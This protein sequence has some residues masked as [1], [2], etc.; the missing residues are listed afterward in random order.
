MTLEEFWR[1]TPR[2]TNLF[3]M[4]YLRR[5]AWAA[6]HS[7]YGMQAKD[8]RIEDLMFGR[9]ERPAMT[10]DQMLQNLRRHRVAQEARLKALAKLERRD[11]G[12]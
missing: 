9:K 3:V 2:L 6:F 11:D 12:E 5:R 8:A 4:G 10:P 7:G 1:S